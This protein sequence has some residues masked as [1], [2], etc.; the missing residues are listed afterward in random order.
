MA[1]QQSVDLKG[2]VAVVTTAGE[3][4]GVTAAEGLLRAGASVSL[5]ANAADDLAQARSEFE[6]QGLQVDYRVVDVAYAPHVVASYEAVRASLGE[7]DI[8]VNHASLRND[9]LMGPENPYPHQPVAFWDL[10]VERVQR[11]VDVNVMGVY[12]CSSVVAAA[13]VARG[14][15]S[16]ITVSTSPSTQR[17]GT[18]IPYG[19]SKAAAEAMTLAM[20]EQLR[21]HGVRCNVIGS[22]GRVN[23]RGVHDPANQPYDCMV[24]FILHLA[25]D[26][27]REV[28]GQVFSASESALH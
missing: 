15:G 28:T 7:I 24:P 8:L 22:G 27:S 9:F 20:A 23:A 18:H 6:A 1:L 11:I 10:Q 21:P 2:K 5:W 3:G 19:P 14:N 26:A 4:E 16:I 25:S 13:M 12:Y 17:A